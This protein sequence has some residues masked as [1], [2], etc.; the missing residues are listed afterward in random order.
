MSWLTKV[1]TSSIGNKLLMSFTGLF[2][3]L[4]L[5]VH[6]AGNLQLLIDDQGHN[7]NEYAEVME[8]NLLIKTV[9]YLLYFSILLH[10]YKGI[11]IWAKNRKARGNK[12]YAVKASGGSTWTSRNM[13]LLGSILFIF[14][15]IHMSQFWYQF[16]FDHDPNLTYFEIVQ[17]GFQ[18]WWIVAFY[19]AAQAALAY[20]LLHGFQSAFQTLGLRI[21]KYESVIRG[22]GVV[23]S[24]A[25]PLLFAI[26]PVFMFMD[27][28]PLSEFKVIP[29]Q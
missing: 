3:S 17:L 20:H 7:F 15:G 14:I 29:G 24:I 21:G 23:F 1:L 6:L 25:I 16:K 2:L 28:Y 11:A 4:F 27:F 10:A 13:A 9:A 18:E 19:V 5:V 22:I 26:I 8:S 12:R